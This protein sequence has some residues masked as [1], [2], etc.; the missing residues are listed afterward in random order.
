LWAIGI[1]YSLKAAVFLVNAATL[2]FEGTMKAVSGVMWLWKKRTVAWNAIQKMAIGLQWAWNAA[3]LANPVGLIIAAIIALVAIAVVL[4]KKFDFV[5]DAVDGFV[6][7][8][9]KALTGLWSMI[10]SGAIMLFDALTWPYRMAWDVLVSIWG[11]LG[12]WFGNIWEGVKEGFSTAWEWIQ[13][14]FNFDAWVESIKTVWG[15]LLSVLTAPFNLMI[16]GVNMIIK[17]LNSISID[18]PDWV[19]IVGGKKFGFNFTELSYLKTGTEIGG[20]GDGTV[21]QLHEGETV[22]NARD[23]ATLASAIDGGMDYNEL[24]K[25]LASALSGLN[26]KTTATKEQLNIALTNTEG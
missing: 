1:F 11:G 8:A 10:K 16:K 13:G 2:I 20:V 12:D 22:L 25:S 15:G 23:S 17:G 24:A 6:T 7:F 5:K 21:A 14:I 9:W 3:M 19:P 4:Y 18:I 26:L